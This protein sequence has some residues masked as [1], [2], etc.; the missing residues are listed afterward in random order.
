VL[1]TFVADVAAQLAALTPASDDLDGEYDPR[2]VALRRARWWTRR[3]FPAYASPSTLAHDALFFDAI[4]RHRSALFDRD[5]NDT[6][7]L[8]LPLHDKYA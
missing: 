5:N 1:A 4:R 2:L 8:Y 6:K 3:H 7:E